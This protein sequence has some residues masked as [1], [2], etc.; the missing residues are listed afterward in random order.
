VSST[1]GPDSTMD[2]GGT[3]PSPTQGA[4][5][6]AVTGLSVTTRSISIQLAWTAV[7]GATAYTVYRD[8]GTE[9]QA[10][11]TIPRTTFTDRPGDGEGHRYSV[12]AVDDEDR[13]GTTGPEVTAKAEAPYGAV[14][15]IASAWTAVVPVTPGKKGTAGQ[16]CKGTSTSADGADGLIKC[17]FGNGVRLTITHYAGEADRDRRGDKLADRK[18]VSD[19]T[20]HTKKGGGGPLTGRLLTADSKAT[21][22]PWRWWTYDAATT[23][24]MYADWPKHTGKQLTS[25]WNGKAPFRT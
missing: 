14:Q 5:L 13:E 12:V 25:W 17:T 23:F 20:W 21:G 22:G 18:R 2:T 4:D 19:G 8:A 3:S 9:G 1:I 16:T 10:V 7:P 24:A 11:R 6:P 15:A